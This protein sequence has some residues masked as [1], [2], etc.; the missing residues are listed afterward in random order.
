[1]RNN[2]LSILFLVLVS[3]LTF[4]SF[5]LFGLNKSEEIL[6]IWA[7]GF[8]GIFLIHY[9]F[10]FYKK[11]KEYDRSTKIVEDL[12]NVYSKGIIKTLGEIT[13]HLEVMGVLETSFKDGEKHGYFLKLHDSTKK[14]WITMWEEMFDYGKSLQAMMA[15]SRTLRVECEE[16]NSVFVGLLALSRK[17][18]MHGTGFLSELEKSKSISKKLTENWEKL[19]QIYSEYNQ[20]YLRLSDVLNHAFIKNYDLEKFKK[21]L[22]K[23]G[24]PEV[25]GF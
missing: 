20:L 18:N 6:K 16:L 17:L 10:E 15:F 14:Q 2:P 22:K 4:I 24:I 3:I 9:G 23:I 25:E 21:E 7:N 12:I 11:Q 19:H 1:M 8:V 13:P 5:F